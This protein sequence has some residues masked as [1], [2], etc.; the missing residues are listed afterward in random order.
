M[1]LRGPTER[2]IHINEKVPSTL[3]VNFHLR[4][5]RAEPAGA[6]R[7]L[8]ADVSRDFSAERELTPVGLLPRRGE[9]GADLCH[10]I[11]KRLEYG[12]DTNVFIVGFV[13][14]RNRSRWYE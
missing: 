4:Y 10:R 8:V 7:N 6:G 3:F 5:P 1:D 12:R 13:C 14:C 2:A 11:L 9:T